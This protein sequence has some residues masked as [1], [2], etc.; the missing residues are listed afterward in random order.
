MFVGQFQ[1]G[2]K[3]GVAFKAGKGDFA[4]K[5]QSMKLILLGYYYS[6]D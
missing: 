1:P 4:F 3:I 6:P 5:V 2:D